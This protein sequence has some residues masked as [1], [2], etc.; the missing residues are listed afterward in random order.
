MGLLDNFK[1]DSEDVND[2]TTRHQEYTSVVGVTETGRTKEEKN[3]S[4]PDYDEM[5]IPVKRN[6]NT[7]ITLNVDDIDNITQHADELMETLSDGSLKCTQCG[8]MSRTRQNMRSHSETHL[9]GL[10]FDCQLCAK[11]ISSRISLRLHISRK[12]IN[13]QI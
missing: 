11:T 10:S 5:K 8:K 3:N 7:T 13:K 2:Y 9:D 12:H 1:S 4:I 6:H